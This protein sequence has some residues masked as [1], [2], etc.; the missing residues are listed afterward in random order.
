MS[1]DSRKQTLEK[2]IKSNL[3]GGSG[4]RRAW[5]EEE[6]P[7]GEEQRPPRGVA[8]KVRNEHL[9]EWKE[10]E[11]HGQEHRSSQGILHHTQPHHEVTRQGRDTPS[12]HSPGTPT[13]PLLSSSTCPSVRWVQLLDA[14]LNFNESSKSIITDCSDYVVIGICGPPCSGKSTMANDIVKSILKR[15]LVPE[16]EIGD[17]LTKDWFPMQTS[18]DLEN[19]RI[20]PSGVSMAIVSVD[21]SSHVVVVDCQGLL[22]PNVLSYLLSQGSA[23]PSHLGLSSSDQALHHQS[24]CLLT[25]L[26]GIC[27]TLLY[28]ISGDLLSSSCQ[29][30]HLQ[31]LM[32]ARALH[33]L[34]PSMTAARKGTIPAAFVNR[35]F[36]SSFQPLPDHHDGPASVAD[37]VFVVNNLDDDSP[38][39]SSVVVSETE[40]Y[41]R[42]T[43]LHVQPSDDTTEGAKFVYLAERDIC[44]DTSCTVSTSYL[45]SVMQL[46]ISAARPSRHAVFQRSPKQ[47]N[48]RLSERDW[49]ASIPVLWDHVYRHSV[50]MSEY[51]DQLSRLN[52]FRRQG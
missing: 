14:D 46:S 51:N 19:S 21:P 52:L 48:I 34:M 17:Y 2:E 5:K 39:T 24:L 25:L 31:L 7:N 18:N 36:G 37:L 10:N 47:H 40:K 3:L 23:G 9:E 27:N 4:N 8:I 42:S 32:T 22:H 49:L 20:P 13:Q 50:Y 1:G 43:V 15:N 38:Y 28:V 44:T 45:N 35:R 26:L 11:T 6:T 29:H 41:I 16:E 33:P 12:T 30:S